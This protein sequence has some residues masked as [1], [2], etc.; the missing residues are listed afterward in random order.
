M[1]AVLG[2]TMDSFLV[3]STRDFQL[4]KKLGQRCGYVPACMQVNYNDPA[5]P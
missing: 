5:Y 3:A 4:L 1:E 2:R